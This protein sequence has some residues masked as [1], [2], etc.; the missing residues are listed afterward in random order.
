VI[1][2]LYIDGTLPLG[3]VVSARRRLGDADDAL[4]ATRPTRGFSGCSSL[5]DDATLTLPTGI[6]PRCYVAARG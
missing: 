6:R 2:N 1:I 4:A 5:L 3:D